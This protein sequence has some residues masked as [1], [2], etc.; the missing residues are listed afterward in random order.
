M[1]RVRDIANI[2]SGVSTD[3]ATDAEV[4]S[5]IASH[6]A[7]ADPH[8]GYL[9]E[10]EYN[11]A[12]KNLVINGAFDVWQRGTSFTGITAGNTYVADRWNTSTAGTYNVYVSRQPTNDTTNLP[13]IQHC[14]RYGR[15]AGTTGTNWNILTTS[16][17]TSNSIPFAGKTIILSFYARAGANF[18]SSG[19][20]LHS[21]VLSGTGTDQ[22]AN[23]AYTGQ[24]FSYANHAL[25]SNWQR[26]TNIYTVPSNATELAVSIQ[27][28]PSGTAGANDWYEIAGVQLE[29][30]S[31]PTNFSRAGGDIQG[32]LAKC[33]RYYWLSP[34]GSSEQK[35]TQGPAYNTSNWISNP[36]TLGV[37]MRIKPYAI[38]YGGSFWL[39]RDAS[40]GGSVPSSIG[41]FSAYSNNIQVV[42]NA[43]STGMTGGTV[44]ELKANSNSS[45]YIGFS[46]EL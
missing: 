14:L 8:T 1:S 27:Y 18:S 29:L 44:Y 26:F 45:T 46:A 28:V 11:V 42:L 10:S 16:F 7:A 33:Q 30:G 24:Q 23:V 21:F 35:F 36:I 12:G 38:D 31:Q 40:Q 4:T 41:I 2:L 32:E 43:G 39:Q 25:T 9:K 17:E 13:S 34:S 3:M 19:N 15:T 22:N 37:P 6:A 5:S 20:L